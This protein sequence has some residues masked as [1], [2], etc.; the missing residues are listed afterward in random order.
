MFKRILKWLLGLKE[1]E[2]QRKRRPK[3]KLTYEEAKRRAHILE[4]LE[5]IRAKKNF[6]YLKKRK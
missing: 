6:K 2:L 5:R 3:K 1:K 4:D